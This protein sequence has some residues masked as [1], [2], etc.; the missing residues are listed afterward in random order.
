[1]AVAAQ[2]GKIFSKRP[3]ESLVMLG[4][5]VYENGEPHKMPKAIVGAYGGLF[6]KGVRA[7]PTLGNHDI[8]SEA[9]K[10]QLKYFGLGERRFY[11][12]PLAAGEV[13]LF[14]VDTT[15]MLA[16]KSYYP[17]GWRATEAERQH[18]WLRQ[19]LA[20]SKAKYKIVIGHHPM[21]SSG[22][23]SGRDEAVIRQQLD[24]ILRDHGVT[25]YMSGHH[26][27]YERSKPQGGVTHFVSGGGGQDTWRKGL[28]APNARRAAGVRSS[29]FMLFELK[30]GKLH[31]ESI[32]ADGKVLDQGALEPPTTG[33][34]P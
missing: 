6:K 18:K 20:S 16:H 29:Q 3:F 10:A 14:S 34:R 4:D 33:A 21:Y 17:E 25:A 32:D 11:K 1:M 22:E 12:T 24:G 8:R 30:S 27:H 5:N 28:E 9:G 2:M 23:S 15:L 19:A 7:L 31:F 13:E 26:H